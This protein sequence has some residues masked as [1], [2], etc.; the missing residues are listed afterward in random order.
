MK[1][2]VVTNMYPTQDMPAYGTFVEEQVNSL[3]KEGVKVDVLFINGRKS[4]LNYL[5]AFFR[6]WIRLLTNRYDL[7]HDHYVF[8]GI[9][10]RA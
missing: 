1:I 9:V 6:L 8:S 5:V 7:I 2:L 4:K 10:A 3:R